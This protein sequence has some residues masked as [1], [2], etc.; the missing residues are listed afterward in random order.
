MYWIMLSERSDEY[1]VSIDDVP[2]MIEEND[3]RFDEGQWVSIDLPVIPIPFQMNTDEILTD[4]I[5]AYGVR[6]LLVNEKI[7]A[8]FDRL[9]P[10]QIQFFRAKLMNEGSQR[11]LAPYWIANVVKRFECVDQ[12][13]SE[14]QYYRDGSIEFID[15]LKLKT[16]SEKECGDIF[17]M[18]EFLPVMV[19]SSR[20]KAGL[21]EAGISGFTF[22]KP[23][24]FSL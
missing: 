15:K 14:L 10:E 11:V 12:E 21:E 6:G 22:Y 9:A 5:V 1:E 3:W 20:L 18:D 2:P 4:N 24:D 13:Q 17:R 19:V 7:K 8:V 16:L 23:E